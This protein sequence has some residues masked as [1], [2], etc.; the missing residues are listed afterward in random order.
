MLEDYTA[1]VEVVKNGKELEFEMS[2]TD[3]IEYVRLNLKTKNSGLGWGTEDVGDGWY[4]L[5]VPDIPVGSDLD[6][7]RSRESGAHKM[8]Y[9]FVFGEGECIAGLVVYYLI[10]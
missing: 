9:D 7:L 4:K 8:E 6:V 3:G 5:N 2:H 10:P 1:V